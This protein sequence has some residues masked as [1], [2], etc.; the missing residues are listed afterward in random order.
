MEAQPPSVLL[1]HNEKW[2]VEKLQFHCMLHSLYSIVYQYKHIKHKV[3]L[4]QPYHHHLCQNSYFLL[5]TALQFCLY[6]KITCSWSIV[7]V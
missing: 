4:E 2:H 7:R 3:F 5:H 6:I 1:E